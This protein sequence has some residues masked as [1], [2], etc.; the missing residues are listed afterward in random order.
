MIRR[1]PRSSLFPYTTLF[2]S[3]EAD[4]GH[5]GEHGLLDA[6]PVDDAGVGDVAVVR[7]VVD[8]RVVAVGAER[9]DAVGGVVDV[10]RKSTTLKS[11]NATLLISVFSFKKK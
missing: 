2:R 8:E 10:D 9:L 7:G 6:G 4:V 5:A 11:S 3:G 1:P